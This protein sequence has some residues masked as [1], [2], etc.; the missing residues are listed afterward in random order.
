MS[1]NGKYTKTFNSY[2]ISKMIQNINQGICTNICS[3]F[4]KSVKCNQLLCI[5]QNIVIINLLPD[6]CIIYLNVIFKTSL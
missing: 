5:V 1:Q 4:N 6:I 3:K 2:F